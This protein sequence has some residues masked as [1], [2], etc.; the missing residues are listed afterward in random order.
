MK[1]VLRWAGHPNPAGHNRILR[2]GAVLE[3]TGLSRST[4]Y[5]MA[6]EGRF[7]S[8]YALGHRAVGWLESD[9]EAWIMQRVQA[10]SS[11]S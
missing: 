11:L 6:K 1:S 3:R 9:V 2:L 7:P 8:Q 5:Q 4:L 10:S